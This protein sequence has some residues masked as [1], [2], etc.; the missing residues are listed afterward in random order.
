MLAAFCVLILAPPPL[1]HTLREAA[2]DLQ[3]RLFPRQRTSAPAT[4]VEI[5]EP[6]LAAYGQWPWPRS[7]VA[8]L[9]E[10]ILASEPAAVGLD[11]LFPEPDR[12]SPA[13]LAETLPQIPGEVSARLRALPGNDELLGRAMRGHPVVLAVAGL[14]E[15][16]PGGDLP[17]PTYSLRLGS[18][19][20]LTR[21][22]AGQGLISSAS[23]TR[24]VRRMPLAGRI[25][26]AVVPALA[27]EMLRVATRAPAFALAMRPDGLMEATVADIRVPAQPDGLAWLRFSRHDPSRFVSAAALLEGRVQREMLASKLVLVG[28]TGLGLIDHVETPLGQR[29]PGV[30]LHAQL[31][32]QIFDGTFLVRPRW[33]AWLE[34]GM[35]AAAVLVL[36]LV[37]PARRVSLS[38]IVFVALLALVA[39]VALG[40]FT[41]YGVLLDSALPALGMALSFGLLLAASL[42]EANRQRRA[43]RAAAERAAGELAAAR[44]IQMGLLPDLA[45]LARELPALELAGFVEPA[46]TVG[47][48]FYDCVRLGPE[49]V[50]FVLAD[51]AGKGMPAALFMALS[52]AILKNAAALGLDAGA[53]LTRAAAEIGRENPEQLFVT[54]FAGIVDLRTGQLDYC[55][56]GHEPPY[57]LAPG[58][59]PQRLPHAGGPPLCTVADFAYRP[60]R[61]QL[62]AG[63]CLCAV[64]DGVTEATDH[65][66]NLYGAERLKKALD[67]MPAGATPAM[68]VE[69]LRDDVLRFAARTPPAD[70]LTVL[71]LAWRGPVSGR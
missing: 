62:A 2:V 50:Y 49:R 41:L 32:E 45:S 4:I 56:A 36:M 51:V 26:G 28:V 5:D 7:R 70:D 23:A 71:A 24:V 47:G 46:R 48:D 61:L 35:L 17:L 66:K 69:A 59:A 14:E 52:K 38:I 16:P 34:V 22:A 44:R 19:P 63:S 20:E 1:A 30:E 29:V 10:R 67:A 39:G 55:N 53:L 25:E 54:A 60:E 64:S 8:A 33:A 18:I 42:S 68:L 58:A 15:A 9:L 21:A 12:Y 3:Q 11:V 27:M 57:L 13:A 6:S 40:A 31:I 43:L 37:V 65:A